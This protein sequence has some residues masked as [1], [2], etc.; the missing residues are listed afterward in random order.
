M[1]N[2]RN[3]TGSDLEQRQAVDHTLLR[4]VDSPGPPSTPWIRSVSGNRKRGKPKVQTLFLEL[5][6]TKKRLEKCGVDA[7]RSKICRTAKSGSFSAT[8]HL[9]LRSNHSARTRLSTEQKYI[10]YK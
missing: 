8:R 7:D 1:A 4:V 10:M 6:L 9:V 2:S 3:K 5:T